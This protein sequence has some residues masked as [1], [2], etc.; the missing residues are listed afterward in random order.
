MKVLII[1]DVH[2]DKGTSIGKNYG[3]G[4]LNSRNEDKFRLLN[5][6]QSK[7]IE[8]DVKHVV[9][10]G[11]VFENYNVDNVLIQ[12]FFSYLK[13]YDSHNIKVH[14]VLGNHDIKR[15]GSEYHSILN[16]VNIVELSGCKVHSEILTQEIEDGFITFVPFRDRK[17]FNCQSNQDALKILNDLLPEKTSSPHLCIGHLTLDG[18][19]YVGDEIDDLHNELHCPAEMFSEKFT[20]TFMGHI[21]KPQVMNE[22]PFV[23]HVGSLDISDF[24]ETNHDKI[25]Y[26]YDS[27]K[28][29]SIVKLDVPTRPLR[30]IEIIIPESVEPTQYLLNILEVEESKRTLYDSILNLEI[31]FEDPKQKIDNKVISKTLEKYSLHNLTGITESRAKSVVST[32]KRNNLNASMSPKD[33]FKDWLESREISE[34]KQPK[35]LDMANNI[36]DEVLSK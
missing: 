19:L 22:S 13:S 36:I 15:I 16:L 26:L 6:V 10:T 4:K 35:I 1:G 32:D 28:D 5:W 12:L 2:L 7:A 25:I 21:H 29:F 11:D 14:I 17:S 33:A 30:K 9:F 18:S 24:G 20:A 34:I 27:N 8:Y 31:K 23:G 3:P